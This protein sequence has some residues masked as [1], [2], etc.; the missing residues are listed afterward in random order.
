MHSS[1]V[2]VETLGETDLFVVAESGNHAC[3]RITV[4][5][6]AVDVLLV[7]MCG[8]NDTLASISMSRCARDHAERVVLQGR[9]APRKRYKRAGVAR[10]A[11]K[12]RYVRLVKRK[13][14]Q[15][16]VNFQ[17]QTEAAL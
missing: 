3:A 7:V 12:R 8:G 5:T 11:S 9:C 15:S 6:T 4:G 16:M 14:G 1:G 13:I 17:T 10:A 2:P